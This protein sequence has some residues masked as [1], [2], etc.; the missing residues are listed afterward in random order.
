MHLL[1]PCKS[2]LQ[3]IQVNF[4]TKDEPTLPLKSPIFLFRSRDYYQ[5]FRPIITK[6]LLMKITFAHEN[7]T[8]VYKNHLLS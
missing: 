8:L 6:I 4:V 7:N 2:C 1:I 3:K 5:D